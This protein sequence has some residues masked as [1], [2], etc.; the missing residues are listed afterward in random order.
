MKAFYD[1]FIN[2]FEERA[3]IFQVGEN[4]FYIDFGDC[5]IQWFSTGEEAVDFLI[6]KGFYYEII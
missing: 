2:V 6:E 4:R 3:I 1:Q 5:F